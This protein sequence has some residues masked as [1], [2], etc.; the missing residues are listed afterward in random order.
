MW[1]REAADPHLNFPQDEYNSDVEQLFGH[2]L[3]EFLLF[4]KRARS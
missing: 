4:T 2:R 1:G 3:S